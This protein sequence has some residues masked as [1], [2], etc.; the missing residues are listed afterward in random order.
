[1][2]PYSLD[3]SGSHLFEQAAHGDRESLRALLQQFGSQVWSHIQ[4]QI[5][6][7]WQSLVDADDVMQVTYIEAFL[8]I[9]RMTARE[10]AGFVAWLKRIA[11][12]NLRD[13]IKELDRKKRPSP[14]RRVQAP[15]GEDSYVALVDMLGV[16]STTPSRAAAGREAGGLVRNILDRLPDDYRTVIQLYDLDCH[17]IQEVADRMERS[18][19]AVHMLRARAHDRMKTLLGDESDFFSDAP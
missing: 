17:P 7:P 4:G 8:H 11:E 10:P 14:T 12:N 19:G 13:A 16:T 3:P 15:A 6:K 1:M 5:G 18:Q 2:E 9:D